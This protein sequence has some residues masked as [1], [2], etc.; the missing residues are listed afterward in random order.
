MWAF[1]AIPAVRKIGGALL[2][3]AMLASVAYAIYH[4]GRR[5]GE[6]AEAGKETEVGRAQFDQ[7]RT[8]L[9]TEL[10]ASHARE[11]QLGELAARFADIA[12]AAS[13]RK[14]A[15]QAAG[16][17][18]A[19]KVNALP[20]S[21]VKADLEAKAGGP[22]ENPAVLRH[23]DDVFT[24]YPHKI[25]ELKATGEEL[26]AVN[27]RLD[28]VEGQVAAVGAQRD[29][30]LAAFNQVVPLYTQAYNA[31]IQGHRKWY[32]LWLCKKKNSMALPEP[33]ALLKLATKG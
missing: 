9:Q 18:D 33:A 30:A 19:A 26:A 12:A 28:A 1:L 2:V 25:D 23:V 11:Q 7:I 29:A 6:Q 3:L 16:Q 20:D 14:E 31:A 32:C 17:A 4:A 15:A 21:A 8:T 27:A 13:Q 5:A 22:L 10:D 24:D